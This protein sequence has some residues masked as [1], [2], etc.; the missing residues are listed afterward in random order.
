MPSAWLA[1]VRDV[2]HPGTTLI[3]T[4]PEAALY[5]AVAADVAVILTVPPFFAVTFPADVTVAMVVSED[6]K[7]MV[8]LA[9]ATDTVVVFPTVSFAA[10]TATL[11]DWAAFEMVNFF[12]TVP[13]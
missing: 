4:V 11:I 5:C 13:L 10:P 2:T 7:D 9:P 1:A 3:V 8:P 12:V 6:L